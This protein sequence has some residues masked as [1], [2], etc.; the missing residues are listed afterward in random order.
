MANK[1]NFGKIA[2]RI[3]SIDLSLDMAN[4]AKNDFL[5]N[6]KTQ[7]FNGKAWQKRKSTKDAGRNLLVK[8]GKLRRDV[9]N[10]VSAGHKNNNMSYTLIVNNAYADY[11]NEGTNRMPKRQFI[12]MTPDLN[13]KLLLKINQRLNKVWGI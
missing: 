7:S 9:S 8:T 13:K 5:N 4:T 11:N 3:K 1:F 12:G 10:S 6:F 2:Q